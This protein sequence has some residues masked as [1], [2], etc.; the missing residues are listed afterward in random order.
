[1]ASSSRRIC[2]SSLAKAGNSS[3]RAASIARLPTHLENGPHYWHQAASLATD[4]L[5]VLPVPKNRNRVSRLFL[6]QAPCWLFS[7]AW[8]RL[9]YA[10]HRVPAL[11]HLD[12]REAPATHRVSIGA[13]SA[14][15]RAFARVLFSPKKGV[16]P[17]DGELPSFLLLRFLEEP[18]ILLFR[19]KRAFPRTSPL[20][21]RRPLSPAAPQHQREVDAVP[22][23]RRCHSE[24]VGPHQQV[25]A[26]RAAHQEANRIDSR[27]RVG[28]CGVRL[29]T[30]HPVP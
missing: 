6:I 22:G 10:W 25:A 20:A 26:S 9:D 24:V 2:K 30:G 16:R 4:N 1:M 3:P 11:L 5:H 19:M 21:A 13:P 8:P 12:R 28:M 15:A 7:R 18:V 23:G 27:G 29:R 14:P 17:S